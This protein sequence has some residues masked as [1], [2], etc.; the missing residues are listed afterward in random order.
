MLALIDRVRSGAERTRRIRIHYFWVKERVTIGEM[1]LEHK[2][3]KKMYANLITKPLQG[4]QF[5]YERERVS[6]A[7]AKGIRKGNLF[8]L[9][10]IASSC[11]VISRAYHCVSNG[12]HP[13]GVLKFRSVVNC[14][15]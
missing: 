8:S 13:R 3:T 2:G 4:S 7:M 6:Y 11:H 12:L 1:V 15:F 10:A 9:V 14:S 5:V